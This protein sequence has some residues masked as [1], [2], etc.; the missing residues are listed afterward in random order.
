MKEFIKNRKDQKIAILL[1]LNPENKG[2]VFVM[3]GLGGFKEQPQM[4]AIAI[5]FSEENYSVV[6]FDT[7]NTLGESDGDYA[8]ATATNYYEDLEDVIAWASAQSWYTEPFILIGHSIGG[9][10][11]GLYAEKYPQ[12]IKALAP[13]STVV[14]GPLSLEAKKTSGELE[15]WQRTGWRISKS[16]SKPGAIKRLKWSHMEDRK[17]YDLLPK[18]E[19]L[20][21]PVLLIVGE[22]DNTTPLEHQKILFAKLPGLKELHVI[23]GA[24]HTFMDPTHLVEIKLILQDWLKAEINLQV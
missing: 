22:E 2:L 24:P 17:Q 23:K 3:H 13:L 1:N 15:E 10:S 11:V 6:Q 21:M 19:A 8:D 12:K 9:L 4:E 16:E 14:S 20:T 18:A 5:T 7:T